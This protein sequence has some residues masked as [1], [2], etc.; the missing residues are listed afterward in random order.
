M[1]HNLKVSIEKMVYLTRRFRWV[2]LALEILRSLSTTIVSSNAACFDDAFSALFRC[3]SAVFCFAG[4]SAHLHDAA[5]RIRSRVTKFR[6][7]FV[8]FSHIVFSS[9]S[10]P[11]CSCTNEDGFSIC[12]LRISVMLPWEDCITLLLARL[13]GSLGRHCRFFCNCT[14]SWCC[15][16][17]S[18]W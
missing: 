18:L 16:Y 13:D 10:R 11:L 14:S 1:V 6:L 5:T 7:F 8:V 4:Y 9:C 17:P 2:L 3:W 15:S 12:L